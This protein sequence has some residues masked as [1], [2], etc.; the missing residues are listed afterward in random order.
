[1]ILCPE[2][3]PKYDPIKRKYIFDN[4]SDED[5]ENEEPPNMN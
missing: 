5:E 4:M 2:G 1:M 3:K